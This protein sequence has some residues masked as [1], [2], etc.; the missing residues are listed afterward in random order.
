VK[1]VGKKVITGDPAH[2]AANRLKSS[3]GRELDHLHQQIDQ[4]RRQQWVLAVSN[5]A[6]FFVVLVLVLVKF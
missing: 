3:V 1:P 5:V 2:L 4:L 6:L